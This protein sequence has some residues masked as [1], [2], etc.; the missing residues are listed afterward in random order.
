MKNNTSY[1][2]FL[3]FLQLHVPLKN[4]ILSNELK[5]EMYIDYLE[6]E[7]HTLIE[8]MDYFKYKYY[9]LDK[10]E[11]EEYLTRKQY[12]SLCFCYSTPEV[13]ENIIDK[14][15]FARTYMS[16]LGR[17]VIIDHTPEAYDNYKQL[18]T[19]YTQLMCKPINGGYGKGIYV[20][21]TRNIQACDEAWKKF[22]EEDYMIEEVICQHSDMAA[23]HPYSVNTIRSLTV[24][25][26]SG[27][28]LLLAAAIRVGQGGCST[29]NANGGGIFADIDIETGAITNDAITHFHEEYAC[30]PDTGIVFKGNSIPCWKDFRKVSL[31]VAE[32][33]KELRLC[34]WDWA[35]TAD[36]HW[37]LI[38]GNLFGGIGLN[39]E[40]ARR[41]LKNEVLMRLI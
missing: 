37:A 10:S 24:V 33:Q 31:K 28:A 34:C 8:P 14:R 25:S 12:E 36:G 15:S 16:Y 17:D 6:C 2:E 26:P 22:L 3:Y 38:E 32:L 18:C 40:A 11:R 13:R 21:D 30:H 7:N 29:D 5:K 39:Q 19:K 41:G 20:F 35:L 9:D 4:S 23:F 27:N 1:S